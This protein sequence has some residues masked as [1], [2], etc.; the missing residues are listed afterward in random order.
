MITTFW[1]LRYRSM[2]RYSLGRE[3]T[4]HLG[5]RDL[6]D[7]RPGFSQA[8]A[9]LEAMLDQLHGGFVEVVDLRE[10]AKDPQGVLELVHIVQEVFIQ[11]VFDLI[12][13]IHQE[14]VEN[15]SPDVH[16]F[17]EEIAE[18]NFQLVQGLADA[19]AAEEEDFGVHQ[20]GHIGVGMPHDTSHS[21]VTG[22]LGYDDFF[23]GHGAQ[24]P[25]DLL[26]DEVYL[27]GAASLIEKSA[28]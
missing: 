11:V 13:F 14:L 28:W 2:L 21:R 24:G 6:P 9:F 8:F 3:I 15:N 23:A 5:N 7:V 20:P 4:L 18:I 27:L 1:G 22:P 10:V 25:V 17:V 16:F 26:A 12:D 19:S